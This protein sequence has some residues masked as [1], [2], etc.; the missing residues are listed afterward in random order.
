LFCC[1]KFFLL[2]PVTLLDGIIF[3]LWRLVMTQGFQLFSAFHG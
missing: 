1:R 3:F 2:V